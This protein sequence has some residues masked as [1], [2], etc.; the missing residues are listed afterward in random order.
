MVQS[1]FIIRGGTI[2]GW[3]IT[4]QKQYKPKK[5]KYCGNKF[6]PTHSHNLYCSEKCRGNSDKEHTEERVRRYRKRYHGVFNDRAILNVGTGGLG[7]HRSKSFNVEQKKIMKELR[8]LGL[9]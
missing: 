6:I 9:R 7:E 4:N 1:V 2:K 8:E 3:Q 5:C